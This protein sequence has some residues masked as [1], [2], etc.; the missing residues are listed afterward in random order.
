MP[1]PDDFGVQLVC[2]RCRTAVVR[3]GDSYL[4]S[5]AECRLRYA[6]IDDIPKFLIDEAVEV[7]PDEWKRVVRARDGAERR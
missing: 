6:I 3:D 5:S 1:F 4:C 7:P 2:P